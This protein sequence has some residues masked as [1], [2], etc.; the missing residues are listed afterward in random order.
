MKLLR[1]HVSAETAYVENGVSYGFGGICRRRWWIEHRPWFGYRVVT[2]TSNPRR[3]G[4]NK[5]HARPYSLE[6]M[7]LYVNNDG[8]VRATRC[9]DAPNRDYWWATFG[10][11]VPVTEVVS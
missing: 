2:Q 3:G 9:E 5:P 1:G 10:S 6:G 11:A 8:V 7:A 4:W